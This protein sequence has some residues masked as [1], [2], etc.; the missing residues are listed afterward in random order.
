MSRYEMKMEYLDDVPGASLITARGCP[1]GCTFCSASAMFGSSY[2]A[3]SP[4]AVVDEV[5]DLVAN[6]GARGV[7][8]FDSTFTVSRRH[9][10]GFCDELARRGVAVPWECEIRVDSV[11]KALLA[12]MQEA[13]CYYVDVGIEAGSQRVLDECVRKRITLERAEE[14]LRWC[15]E[16]GLLTKVFFTLGHPGETY[17]E[18]KETNRF[19]RRN[20][21]HVRLFGYHAGVKVYPGTYVEQYAWEHGLMPPGF[22]WSAPYVNE[23]QRRLFRAPDNIPILLQPGLGLDELRRLRVDFIKMRLS[24][25]RFVWEK[26]KAVAKAGALG[27]YAAVVTRGLRGRPN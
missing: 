27:R 19:I 25:P 22:R 5:E 21:K 8:I 17:E 9:V 13:G 26:V 11:D 1:I 3:R 12:R 23:G 2:R 4:R 18:A 20:R 7:K 15:D 14:T 10:E 16:L 6:H 24:S